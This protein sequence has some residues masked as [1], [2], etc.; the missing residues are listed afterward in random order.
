MRDNLDMTRRSLLALVPVMFVAASRAARAQ[1]TATVYKD[2]T[3]GCCGKWVDLLRK[4]GFAV[5]VNDVR[6]IA[7]VKDKYGVPQP[8]R[9]CHTALINGYVVEGHVPIADVKRLLNEKAAAAGLAVPGMPIGSPGME[10]PGVTPQSYQVIAF[11]ARGG[12]RVFATYR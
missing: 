5:T 2:P 4:D 1:Q 11:D 8:L 10:V 12:S 9:S 6:D 3:C 7:A